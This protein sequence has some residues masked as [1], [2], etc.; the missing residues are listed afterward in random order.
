M[1]D[2][3]NGGRTACGRRPPAVAFFMVL[4]LLSATVVRTA[5]AASPLELKATSGGGVSPRAFV[6]NI[7]AESYFATDAGR[8][9]L[10][11]LV[12]CAFDATTEAKLELSGETITYAG[13][14]G[15]APAWADRPLSLSEQRWVSACILSLANKFGKSVKVDLRGDHPKLAQDTAEELQSFPLHEG[16]FFGNLFIARPVAYVCQGRDISKISAVPIGSLRACAQSSSSPE[17]AA[18]SQCG[19]VITG[20]CV[21]PSSFMVNGEKF[22]EVIQVWLTQEP[23]N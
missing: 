15:L 19:F 20:P 11:Y 12:R 3:A 7:P 5:V 22:E 14:L 1:S 18:L 8:G 13:G 9:L 2:D 4:A 21:S 23:V 10:K 6:L 17:G 16:G